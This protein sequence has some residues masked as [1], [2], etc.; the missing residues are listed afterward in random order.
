MSG[1]LLRRTAGKVRDRQGMTL[2]ETVVAFALLM[3]V[4]SVFASI[5][6]FAV[7][8]S[9]REAEASQT[10]ILADTL[11]TCIDE[12]LRFAE[13][14]DCDDE[15]TEVLFSGDGASFA[16][17]GYATLRSD[18]SGQLV[19][20]RG[21]TEYPLLPEADYA[22]MTA[23]LTVSKPQNGILKM[24]LTVTEPKYGSRYSQEFSV[25]LANG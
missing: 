13:I 19:V 24:T 5:T 17:G 4:I 3:L 18:D 14:H 9:F 12:T 21:G 8:I 1:R 16:G 6:L 23:Q 25:L 22:G 10:E 15:D 2:V 20:Q 7:N 11:I